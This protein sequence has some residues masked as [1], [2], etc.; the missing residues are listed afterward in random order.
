[1]KKLILNIFTLIV[2]TTLLIMVCLAWYTSN[3]NLTANGI[4]AS[5]LGEEYSLKLQRGIKTTENNQTKWLWKDTNSL[6]FVNLN[7]DNTFYFRIEIDA[8]KNSSFQAT[9][10][11]DNVSSELQEGKL[12]IEDGYVCKYVPKQSTST[13]SSSKNVKLYKIENN[14]VTVNVLKDN[15]SSGVIENYNTSKTLYTI[16]NNI[17]S[18]A[19]LKIENVFKFYKFNSEP[20]ATKED[21]ALLEGITPT[22]L[23][24]VKVNYNLTST[25]DK[26]YLY[27]ALEFNDNASLALIDGVLSSNAYLYQKLIIGAISVMTTKENTSANTSTKE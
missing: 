24:D 22:S 13:T 15:S 19:D 6:S 7:P 21:K 4:I 3:K 11:F 20:D 1:M 27:F 8:P 12:T 9:I 2:T 18:L 10:S 23:K 26:A 25:I 17:I 16:D 5:T 14:K